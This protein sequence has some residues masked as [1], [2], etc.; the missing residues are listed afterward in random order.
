MI[1]KTIKY[2]VYFLILMSIGIFYLSYYG[3]ETNK[4]NQIIKDKISENNSKIDIE[5]KKVKVILNL[6]KFTVSIKTENPNIIV[7]KNKIKLAK[8]RADFL[9]NSFFEKKNCYQECKN[10]D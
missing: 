10:N 3:I 1:K 9:I 6:R 7:E 8:I 4:F 2:F 5:L